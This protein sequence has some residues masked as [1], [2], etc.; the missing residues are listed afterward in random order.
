MG[1]FRF[2]V[3]NAAAMDDCFW[4]TAFVTGIEGIPWAGRSRLEGDLFRL[5]RS[6]DESGKLSMVWPTLEYGPLTLTSAS[7]RCVEEAYHLPLELAR[8]TLHRIRGSCARLATAG[9]Q[10]PR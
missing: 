1:Q 6:I 5:E 2:R 8:G 4:N 10:T 9:P 3:P 7:L